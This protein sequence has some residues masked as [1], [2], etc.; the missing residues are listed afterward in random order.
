MRIVVFALLAV[1]IQ[2]FSPSPANRRCMTSLEAVGRKDFLQAGGFMFASAVLAPIA[3]ADDTL[4]SGVSYTVIKKGDGP[5]PAIGELA[6]I[7]FKAF[8][9]D[10]KI[11]D[12]FDTP[13]P[14][15]TRVGSGGMIKVRAS[16]QIFYHRNRRV[17]SHNA[18]TCSCD[19][20]LKKSFPS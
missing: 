10:I 18:M 19:R 13:E 12:I 4:P 20:E 14:L 17:H 9:G 3:W 2:A 7:R 11:D 8:N 1:S 16:D 6:A 15:Y 5:A